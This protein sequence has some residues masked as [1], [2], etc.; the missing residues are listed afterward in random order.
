MGWWN[1]AT[2]RSS[3]NSARPICAFRSRI[4][5]PGRSGSTDRRRG[6]IWRAIRELTFEAP[7]LVRFP[8]LALARRVLQ[9][10]GAAPTVFNAANE[11]A[12]AEFLA[13]RIAF[14]TITALVEATLDAAAGR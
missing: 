5:W 11:V 3:P 7:D 12:V 6:S 8:A 2:A 14:P 13:G 1:F 4:A 9:T 10:G